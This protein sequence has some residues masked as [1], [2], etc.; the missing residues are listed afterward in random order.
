MIELLKKLSIF[1]LLYVLD[2]L[3]L[4]HIFLV[5]VKHR[6]K[7]VFHVVHEAAVEDCSTVLF[8]SLPE[9]WVLVKLSKNLVESWYVGGLLHSYLGMHVVLRYLLVRHVGVLGVL[10]LLGSVEHLSF[11]GLASYL[12]MVSIWVYYCYLRL[13]T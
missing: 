1:F 8:V 4:L 9:T 3:D 12:V 13:R 11:V 5:V 7:G 2:L 10:L 6:M